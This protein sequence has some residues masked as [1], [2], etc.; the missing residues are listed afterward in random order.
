[1]GVLA[2]PSNA[3]ELLAVTKWATQQ[4][5]LDSGIPAFTEGTGGS[6]GGALRTAEGLRTFTEAVSRGMKMIIF[7]YDRQLTCDV[8][9][10][11]ANW[12]LIYDDDMELKG[13]VEVLANGMMGRINKAQNDQ[14]RLQILNMVLNS[15]M[16]SSI[17]GVKGILE[18]FRPSLKDVNVNPD[19]VAPSAERIEM[20]E[21]IESIKQVFAATQASEG[22]QQ[23]AAAAQG[24]GVPPGIQQPPAVQGAVSERRGVA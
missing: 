21:Q 1:M 19:N 6:S 12:V 10:R 20:L 13:D 24:G 14:A 18:L 16:L 4:A 9:R 11:T 5:D 23:N 8:A 3:S 22:V 17:L 7:I 15:Q 2:I